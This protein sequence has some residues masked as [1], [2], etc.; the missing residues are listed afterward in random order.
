M[1]YKFK[2]LVL[3]GIGT[4]LMVPFTVVYA[5]AGKL[6]LISLGALILSGYFFYSDGFDHLRDGKEE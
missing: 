6:D 1:N 5:L 3:M 2:N 4:C